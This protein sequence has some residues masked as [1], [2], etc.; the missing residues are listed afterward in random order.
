MS[1]RDETKNLIGNVFY[2]VL[3]HCNYE[4]AIFVVAHM[5]SG[6]TALANVLCSHPEISG[7][8][9]AHIQ[10][11]KESRLGNLVLS[12]IRKSSWRYDSKYLFDKILHNRYDE[13]TCEIFLRSKF[14]FLAREPVPAVL[15]IRNLFSKLGSKEYSTDEEASIYYFKRLHHLAKFW[16][17]VPESNR[18]G[19]THKILLEEPENQLAKLS[20]FL[21]LNE[22]LRNEYKK[23]PSVQQGGVGDPLQASNYSKIVKHA[24]KSS[25]IDQR[26]LEISK[27][28]ESQIIS[29]YQNYV[30]LVTANN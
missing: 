30:G 19:L 11:Q 3:P 17:R 27:N 4:N 22:S 28:S 10:Y 2:S 15:S 6:T 20:E 16:Q 29:A 5:R 24:S 1:F 12:Q 8:G 14:V 23:N 26:K 9:E 18:F 21:Q 13:N 7:F 25:T